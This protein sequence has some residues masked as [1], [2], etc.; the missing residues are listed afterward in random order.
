MACWANL[1]GS[2][3]FVCANP[4]LLWLRLPQAFLILTV[5]DPICLRMIVLM[6]GEKSDENVAIVFKVANMKG[7]KLATFTNPMLV[8]ILKASSGF[9]RIS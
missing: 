9:A 7:K 5:L 6:L 2:F 3:P 1:G 8:L 4:L